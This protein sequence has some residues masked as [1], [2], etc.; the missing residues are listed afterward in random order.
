MQLTLIGC[1]GFIGQELVPRLLKE[2]HKLTIVSRKSPPTF[3]EI[4]QTGKINNIYMDPTNQNAWGE[5]SIVNALK[6][7]EGIINLAGEPIADKRWTEEHCKKIETSRLNTTN[8]LINALKEAKCKPK[9]IINASAIGFYGTSEEQ[10]FS[11][12]SLPGNDFLAK[13]CERWEAIARQRPK[14]TRIVILRIGIVLGPNG[15]ALKKMLPI[16][17]AGLGGPIG[18]GDQWMSWIHRTDICRIIEHSLNNSLWSG[19]LN[20]VAPEPTKMREFAAE[21]GSCLGR[22]SILPVPGQILK[23]MLGD[24]AKVVL[25][26]QYVISNKLTKL[27]FKFKYPNLSQALYLSTNL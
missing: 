25:E 26:G 23:L 5:E 16:F 1:T 9:V 7:S 12:E 20:C 4:S 15:G 27:G 14:R 10:R 18:N 17:K 8:Y 24:G 3:Q 6:N 19:V 11:E 21:L 13:L 22:P 2:G